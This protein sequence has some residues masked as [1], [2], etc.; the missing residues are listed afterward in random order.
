MQKSEMKRILIE[1]NDK[2]YNDIIV[3]FTFNDVQYSAQVTFAYFNSKLD[4]ILRKYNIE[5]DESYMLKDAMTASNYEK[6]VDTLI[7]NMHNQEVTIEVMQD[8]MLEVLTLFNKIIIYFD[9]GSRVS[10]DISLISISKAM[11]ENPEIYKLLLDVHATADMTPEEISRKRKEILIKMKDLEIPGISELMRAGAGVKPDQMLNMFFG[12][13]LRVKPSDNLNEIYPKF[14]PERWI[15]GIKFLD[16]HFVEMSIQ[17]LAAILNTQTMKKSGTHNK[18]ASIL[19]QDT[20]IVE[21]DCGSKNYQ[22][23]VIEDE[24]DLASL[25]FRYMVTDEENHTLKEITK[26]DKHLIGTTVKIRSTMMCA[27]EEGVCA[28]CFGS[29]A[30]WN[31][32]TDDYRY[33]V[34][35]VSAR[36]LN[37]S[38]SQKVLSPKHNSTPEL[39]PVE[40]TVIDLNSGEV[41]YDA[42]ES[43][44]NLFDRKF[45]NILFKDGLKIYFEVA[46]VVRRVNKK[47]TKK[48]MI[49]NYEDNEFGEHDK[50][51]CRKLY[52]EDNDKTYLF[53]CNSTF[54]LSGFPKRVHKNFTPSMTVY[55][56]EENNVSYVIRNHEHVVAFKKLQKVYAL[57][58]I[59]LLKQAKEEFS[60]EEIANGNVPYLNNQIEYMY[61]SIKHVV[62]GE[63]ALCVELSLRNKIIN[64]EPDGR[65]V[66]NWRIPNPKYEILSVNNAITSKPTISA[67]LPKGYIYSRF[68]NAR[69]HDKEN[70]R[71][72]VFD[73]LF[74][75]P[76]GKNASS[77]IVSDFGGD[78]E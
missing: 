12:L 11:S 77:N 22:S 24:K 16:S 75:S 55:L 54:V 39:V 29:H 51:R 44:P 19:A 38:K 45:N 36:K 62:K 10:H 27:S 56:T 65:I 63:P 50:I 15:D 6:Y 5:Y 71:F 17:R 34:G 76:K 41:L 74:F 26:K 46:D 68:T 60:A 14:I 57:S 25:E 23:Y 31:L 58:T 53:E 49:T 28:T 67:V 8:V 2:D 9:S 70:L 1:K 18:D 42:S 21:L 73:L 3:E 47:N 69:Y 37:S 13:Y 35:F 72:S 33:D 43:C 20:V 64:R 30:A 78:G 61:N 7:R 59:A 4:T 48:S 52:I 40:F 66:P 32:S